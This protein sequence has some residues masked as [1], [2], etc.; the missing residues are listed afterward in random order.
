ME[1]VRLERKNLTRRKFLKYSGAAGATILAG[2]NFAGCLDG[3]QQ[4]KNPD[5]I[6]YQKT[7]TV[8]SF[9]PAWV[10]DTRSGEVLDNVYET[11]IDYDET[12]TSEFVSILSKEVPTQENGLISEDGTTYKFPIKEGVKFHNGNEL[13]PEDVE[14][15]IERAMVQDR[16]GGPV[17]MFTEP[18]LGRTAGT[19]GPE[20]NIAVT[21]D[22]IDSCVEVDG[23]QVVFNLDRP[24]PPFLQVIAGSWASIVNKDWAI[25]QGDWPGTGENWQ[26]YN[27][28]EEGSEPLGEVTNGT[29]PYQ[30]DNWESGTSLTLTSHDDYWGDPAPVDNVLIE[31]VGEFS[32]RKTNL[33]NGD[34]DIIYVPT[35]QLNQIQDT[36]QIDKIGPQASL[37]NDAV[38]MTFNINREGQSDR[39]AEADEW[40][41]DS[42]PANFFADVNVRKAFAKAFDYESYIEDVFLGY[43]IQPRSPVP[44]GVRYRDT[45]LEKYSTDL[46]AAETHLKE[47]HD[48]ALWENGFSL[49]INYNSGNTQRQT[50]SRVIRDQITSLND[51]FEINIRGIQWG[52]YLNQLVSGKLPLFVIGW[53]PDYPDPHNYLKPYMHSSGTFSG[54][55]GYSNDEVDQLIEQGIKE[56]DE[57]QRKQIY[58][59]LQGIYKQ[60]TP[61]FMLD[62][63]ETFQVQRSWVNGY[64]FNPI[65]PDLYYYALSKG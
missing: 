29:G 4:V 51:E 17:W 30:L 6:V 49:T 27:N 28:P 53:L 59:D 41:G 63:P 18:L 26:E 56:T 46:E 40:T 13:T 60:D 5:T 32:T 3:G 21:Y 14:Y 47:A 15:S 24:Y 50:A 55:Q 23:N 42:I 10:Y 57:E 19:R 58:Y 37:Q 48:G 31:N 22:D 16:A 54:S 25:E 2:T 62:Q 34:A 20:G 52:D 9:D 33:Q 11:L 8:D 65:Y 43:A 7:G 38:F 45:S 12:S 1:D 35:Q 64:Y 36:D 61:S 39:V 44:K